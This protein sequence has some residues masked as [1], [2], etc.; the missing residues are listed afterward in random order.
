MIIVKA[1]VLINP[2]SGKEE[3]CDY[4]APIKEK[5]LESFDEVEIAVVEDSEELQQAMR[6]AFEEEMDAVFSVGGDGTVNQIIEEL[7]KRDS[8]IKLG[9]FPGGTV[10][11]LARTLGISPYMDEAIA[12]FSIEKTQCIDIGK[13]NDRYF[14]M[15]VSIGTVSEALMNVSTEDKNKWGPMAYVFDSVKSFK[16][17]KLYNITIVTENE[18]FTGV[19][20]N[21]VVALKTSI[22]GIQF[23]NEEDP[24]GKMS[25]FILGENTTIDK[26][27]LVGKAILGE[28]EEHDKIIVL[29]GCKAKIHSVDGLQLPTDVD[30]DEGPP[31]PIELEVLQEKIE[32]YVP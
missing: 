13:I 27:S 29:K 31:L 9:I 3:G 4:R 14:T 28:V 5:L 2:S 20:S 15:R 16:D 24:N 8:D 25:I 26:F 32:V 19:V 17:E 30:G 6:R 11:D 21:I 7:A 1:M 22:H 10:N 23:S 18:S 12:N